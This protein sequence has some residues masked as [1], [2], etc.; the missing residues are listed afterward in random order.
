MAIVLLKAA[1]DMADPPIIGLFV[2][3]FYFNDAMTLSWLFITQKSQVIYF[4]VLTK[5]A[6]E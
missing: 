3:L 1:E 2:D 4:D 6:I 5:S